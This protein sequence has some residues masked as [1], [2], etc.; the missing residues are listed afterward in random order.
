MASDE[1]SHEVMRIAS[2][3]LKRSITATLAALNNIP[4]DILTQDW[5]NHVPGEKV[6]NV[7]GGY[8]IAEGETL[9]PEIL[10]ETPGQYELI[11]RRC[12]RKTLVVTPRFVKP[13][14]V[15][16]PESHIDRCG[17]CDAELLRTRKHPKFW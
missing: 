11:C 7:A 3:P 9:R 12:D 10:V 16:P 13:E 17:L 6:V 1:L 2:Q 4:E 15:M 5:T 14:A 8:G